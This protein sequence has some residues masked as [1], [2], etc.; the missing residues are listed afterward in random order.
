MAAATKL[1]L[2]IAIYVYVYGGGMDRKTRVINLI[3]MHIIRRCVRGARATYAR[4]KER[5]LPGMCKFKAVHAE[6]VA[7][8]FRFL[9][10]CSFFSGLPFAFI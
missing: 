2:F 8:L 6:L 9:L 3:N 5:V 7:H 1:I 10:A 4:E